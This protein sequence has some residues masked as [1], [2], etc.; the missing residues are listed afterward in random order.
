[1]I[2]LDKADEGAFKHLSWNQSPGA[3]S[4][5]GTTCQDLNGISNLREH[6]GAGQD[7]AGGGSLFD[8]MAASEAQCPDDEYEP[9]RGA[10]NAGRLSKGWS[11]RVVAAAGGEDQHR[12]SKVAAPGC[13]SQFWSW[14]TWLLSVIV[15]SAFMSNNIVPHFANV[16]QTSPPVSPA[17]G[18]GNATDPVMATEPLWMRKRSSTCETGGIS[19]D[20]FNM[21]LHGG[22]VLII[23]FVSTSACAF[24]ILATK[25]PGLKIPQRFFFVVRHFGT[26]VLIATAFVHLLPTAFGSLGDPCLSDFWTTDYP[27]MPGAIALAAIFFVTV[28]EMIF[29]PGRHQPPPPESNECA[30]DDTDLEMVMSAPGAGNV[31]VREVRPPFHSRSSS[32]GQGLAQLNQDGLEQIRATNRQAQGQEKSAVGQTA[33]ASASQDSLSNEQKEQKERLQC[34]LLE[35]GILFHSVFIGMALSVSIGN[36][37]VILLIAIIFHQMFEGLALGARISAISWTKQ[38][39]QPWLMAIA[40]GLT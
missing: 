34:V 16:F 15:V 6:V 10:L 35:M 3:L 4:A 22:A 14:A 27:A 37:F 40:Y 30:A 11:A 39:K 38:T 9:R 20:E 26:G 24:P 13:L 36:S 19:K 12:H 29:H 5:D 7:G 18:P 8:P 1:M 23:W 31:P 2:C 25:F 32:I 17:A 28:I 21:P 33:S